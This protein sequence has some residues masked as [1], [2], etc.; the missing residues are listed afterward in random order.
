MPPTDIPE[1]AQ[2]TPVFETTW[3]TGVSEFQ[4][5]Q[6]QD[7][8]RTLLFTLGNGHRYAINLG[9]ALLGHVQKAVSPVAVA[10][11]NQIPHNGYGA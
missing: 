1:I 8:T 3:I 2:K 6:Q 10:G 7:G 5:I 11:A 9:G 4:A